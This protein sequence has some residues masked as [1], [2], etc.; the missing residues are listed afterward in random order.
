MID[1]GKLLGVVI[2][3]SVFEVFVEIEV[4]EYE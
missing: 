1:N 3:G 2:C 4:N